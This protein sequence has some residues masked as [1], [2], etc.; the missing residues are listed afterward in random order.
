MTRKDRLQG[1]TRL[2]MKKYFTP[3]IPLET[4]SKEVF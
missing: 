1:E 4:I 2:K 3:T